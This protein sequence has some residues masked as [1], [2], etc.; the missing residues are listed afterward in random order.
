MVSKTL[1]HAVAKAEHLTDAD[2]ERIGRNLEAYVDDLRTLRVDLEQGLHSLDAG[3]G[4]ELDVEDVL[5]RA[6]ANHGGA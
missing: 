6:R 3:L 4:R 1:T 2:Q 5:A